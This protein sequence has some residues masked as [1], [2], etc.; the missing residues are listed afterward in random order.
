MEANSGNYVLTSDIYFRLL[1]SMIAAGVAKACKRTGVALYF[2]RRTFA[3]FKPRM[4]R[5]LK[6][7]VLLS[8]VAALAEEIDRVV[9]PSGAIASDVELMGD[10][11]AQLIGDQVTWSSAGS[12][13]KTRAISNVTHWRLKKLSHHANVACPGKKSKYGF[14]R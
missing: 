9:T 3:E 7:I 6:D 2:G 1:L 11:K 5:I 13:V 4:E 14:P 8:E 12:N 10:G